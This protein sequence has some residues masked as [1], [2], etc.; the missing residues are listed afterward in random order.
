MQKKIA[1]ATLQKIKF[2]GWFRF[3]F[4]NHY[5]KFSLFCYY[6]IHFLDYTFLTKQSCI[7]GPNVD[8]LYFTQIVKGLRK[9]IGER[10]SVALMFVPDF[11]NQG[12]LNPGYGKLLGSSVTSVQ[13]LSKAV[14]VHRLALVLPSVAL[15]P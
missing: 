12:Y 9:N 3:I 7:L 11:G 2:A 8:S 6:L 1:A 4:L 14:E 5:Y 15:A 13:R 10:T